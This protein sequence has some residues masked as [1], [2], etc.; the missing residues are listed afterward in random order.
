MLNFL[1][2]KSIKKYF[3]HE[4]VAVVYLFGS[5]ATGKTNH[6]SD[7]DFGVIFLENM[8]KKER[9]NKRLE[10]MGFLGKIVRC[11]NI[12]V[13]DLKESPVFLQYSAIFPRKDIYIKDEKERIAFEHSTLSSY[14][15]RFF[16]LRRHTINSL[17][18]TAKEGL[19][20]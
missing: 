7:Y 15:D 20:I 2:I 4:P 1:K 9:F 3:T 17:A 18:T 6:R 16:Y 19:A 5:Q 11:D 13:I 12:E 10:Y 8:S 14:F